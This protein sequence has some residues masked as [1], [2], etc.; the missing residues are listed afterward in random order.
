[1]TARKQ[2]KTDAILLYLVERANQPIELSE[3]SSD[4]GFD[5]KITA[6]IASRLASKGFIKKVK[7]GTYVYREKQAF[8]KS[9]IEVVCHSLS[10]SITKTFGDSL[11]KKL[12]IKLPLKNCTTADELES[13]LLRLRGALGVE[14]ANNLISVVIRNELPPRSRENLMR[15][16][17]V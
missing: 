8:K 12:G 4:L 13:I 10:E 6:S 17:D 14:A 7:R 9:E 1:M 16:L 5:R 3:M 15:R 2:S 11:M